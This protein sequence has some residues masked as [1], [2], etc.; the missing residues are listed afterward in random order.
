MGFF[1]PS[2]WYLSLKL[3]YCL[4]HPTH[5]FRKDSMFVHT[6]CNCPAVL[7][8][9]IPSNSPLNANYSFNF[10]G[11]RLL[12]QNTSIPTFL[13]K[14]CNTHGK[15]HANKLKWEP[16]CPPSGFPAPTAEKSFLTHRE[17][18]VHQDKTTGKLLKP[19]Y[20]N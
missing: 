19:T 15:T 5:L 17:V 8:F 7:H 18:Q 2:K 20:C 12:H 13:P 14:D 6:L 11:V 9:H 1:F 4:G 16:C 3:L 10:S